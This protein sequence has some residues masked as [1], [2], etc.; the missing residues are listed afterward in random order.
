MS[1]MS[2]LRIDEIRAKFDRVCTASAHLKS[3]SGWLSLQPSNFPDLPGGCLTKPR[4]FYILS[5][6]TGRGWHNRIVTF[7]SDQRSVF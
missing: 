5:A 6:T 2:T 1:R 7:V 3:H 4:R